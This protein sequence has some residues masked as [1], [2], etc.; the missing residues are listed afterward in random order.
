MWT[1]LFV[2][3][4]IA[5]FGKMIGF[6]VKATWGLTK[7]LFNLVLLP[8]FLIG[9]VFAGLMYIALPLL[10]IVGVIMLVVKIIS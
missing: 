1:A 7:I 10:V 2:I 5:V 3:L 8:V 6:A 4:T 9:L